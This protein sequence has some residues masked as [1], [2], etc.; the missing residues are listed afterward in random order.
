MTRRNF[1]DRA[2]QKSG[3]TS[4]Y[5]VPPPILDHV[6]LAVRLMSTPIYFFGVMGIWKYFY[7]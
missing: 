3:T 4:E 5:D 1:T 7:T 2:V 6:S